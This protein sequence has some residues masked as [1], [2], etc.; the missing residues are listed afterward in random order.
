MPML[1]EPLVHVGQVVVA[2]PFGEEGLDA[3]RLGREILGR[4]VGQR[5]HA[6][7]LGHL[8]LQLG[9]LRRTGPSG[10]AASRDGQQGGTQF[11][12]IIEVAAGKL[13]DPCARARDAHDIAL[14]RQ[15]DQRLAHRR[16]ADRMRL[17]ENLFFQPVARP[18][19]APS[20][21]LPERARPAAPA[22]ISRASRAESLRGQWLAWGL[23]RGWRRPWADDSYSCLTINSILTD[24]WSLG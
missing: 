17:G 3:D 21:R 18:Q 23:R 15:R 12:Q 13:G 11:E 10:V 8:R 2:A 7:K 24:N 14:S 1:A 5:H 6:F 20:S 19:P 22:A 16:A 4:H 9:A